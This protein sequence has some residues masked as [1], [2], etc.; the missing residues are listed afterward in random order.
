MM[1]VLERRKQIK[2]IW[3]TISGDDKGTSIYYFIIVCSIITSVLFVR[4]I[5]KT[6]HIEKFF[7]FIMIIWFSMYAG[8]Y[9]NQLVRPSK[10]KKG[11]SFHNPIMGIPLYDTFSIL[12]IKLRD[13]KQLAFIHWLYSI[14][15]IMIEVIGTNVAVIVNEELSRVRDWLVIYSI[16]SIAIICITYYG[17]VSIRGCRPISQKLFQYFQLTIVIVLV[18]L[19]FL[20]NTFE[21]LMNSIIIQSDFRIG[22][23]NLAGIPI[24]MAMFILLIGFFLLF[25][26]GTYRKGRLS[27]WR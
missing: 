10:Q 2:K 20:Y 4:M 19:G 18:L 22:L 7:G 13:V 8:L 1:H 17:K 27:S 26:L 3:N 12:P 23:G 15:P 21:E 25:F 6:N 16:G 5:L 14:I 24:I 9:D 11:W